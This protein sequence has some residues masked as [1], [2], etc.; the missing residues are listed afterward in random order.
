MKGLIILLLIITG[1][2]LFAQDCLKSLGGGACVVEEEGKYG[3]KKKDKYIVPAYFDEL[4]DHSSKYFS[5]SQHDKWGI[6][7]IKGHLILTVSAD[8]VNMINAMDGLM[9]AETKDYHAMVITDKLVRPIHSVKANSFVNASIYETTIGEYIAFM[10]DLKKN[11]PSDFTY[12]LSIPDTAKMAPAER[13]IFSKFFVANDP[14]TEHYEVF[15]NKPSLGTKIPCSIIKDKKLSTYLTLPI[16]GVSFKQV[17]RFC[18]WLS[19]KMNNELCKDLPYEMIIRLPKPLEWEQMAVGGLNDEM[20]PNNC[21][22]SLNEKKCMLLNYRSKKEGCSSI[23][24][25]VK[26]YGDNVSPV[27]AYYPDVNGVYNLFGNVAEMTN[28]QGVCKGGSYVHSAKACSATNQLHYLNPE[29]WLGFRW[30]A[31]YRM[32]KEEIKKP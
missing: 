8:K 32:K 12:E 15:K 7:D 31:E 13:I 26:K 29:P 10:Y 9:Y 25:M 6:F 24:E 14:C 1:S 30:V 11:P 28:E 4:I 22:D 3:V 23:E 21:I 20:R 19:D 18:L 27:E 2:N 16:T 5:V 17:Q